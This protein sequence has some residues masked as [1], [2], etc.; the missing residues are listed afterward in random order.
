MAPS[1]L[2]AG[3]TPGLARHWPFYASCREAGTE[4]TP[5][6]QGCSP[7]S[8]VIRVA[9]GSLSVFPGG[10]CRSCYF[11]APRTQHVVGI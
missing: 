6:A 1:T 11:C 7:H 2:C 3:T 10:L 4:R 5:T 9:F 8:F